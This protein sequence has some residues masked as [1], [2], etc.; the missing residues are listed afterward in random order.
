MSDH[1]RPAK[2]ALV[3]WAGMALAFVL[4]SVHAFSVLLTPLEARFGAS[5]GEVSFSYSL[6]LVAITLGVLVGHRVYARL[7]P[8]G[9]AALVCLIA[10]AGALLAGQAPTLAVFWLGFGVLYGGAN[11]L[12]YGYA[13]QVAA[14]ANSRRA[15]F[16]MGAVTACYAL[17]A[18][19][20]PVVLVRALA[21]GGLP[22]AMT[23]LAICL[24]A[25][26]LLVG[27]LLY[28]GHAAYRGEAPGARHHDRR[29]VAV[30][31]FGY[32]TGV[33]AGLMAI[34]HA[35]GIAEAAGLSAQQAVLA[36]SVIAVGNMA[37]GLGAGWLIDRVAPKRLLVVLPL[38]SSAGLAWL[39]LAPGVLIGLAVVGL[40]YGATIAA[41]PAAIALI[42]GPASAAR[43]Y[44]RVFT[45]WGLAG[46]G[47]AWLAGL[48]YQDTGSYALPLAIALALSLASAGIALLLR[49]GR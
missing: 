31:W 26:L 49:P 40:G 43:V 38:V 15:G 23:V 29:G 37:G 21:S 35:A 9:L 34:G 5:R 47:A 12:G 20:F 30:L 11:G 2:G 19:L 22:W 48:L 46:L 28:F 27:P 39:A 18:A 44:G 6:A 42:H 33:A 1:S 14:Q 32:A 36:P 13:L 8:L 25:A 45:A 24:L 4:G 7:S 10:G 17:G 3:L 41:Y 16:A